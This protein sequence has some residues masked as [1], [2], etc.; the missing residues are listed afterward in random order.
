[1]AHHPVGSQ[2]TISYSAFSRPK[3]RKHAIILFLPDP[4]CY[5]VL[6]CSD[7][8]FADARNFAMKISDAINWINERGTRTGPYGLDR[9]SYFLRSLKILSMNM[10]VC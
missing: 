3:V 7:Q 5:H 10:P 9:I 4:F 6:V 1:M 8:I 2:S